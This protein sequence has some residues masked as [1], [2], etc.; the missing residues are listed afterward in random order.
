MIVILAAALAGCGGSGG[1][2]QTLLSPL[3]PA[4]IDAQE[5]RQQGTWTILV[6]L[7]ADNDLET[8]GLL[9]FNQME[10][11]GSTK[12]VRIVVQ[13]DR[14]AGHDSTN[15]NWTDT[16]RY[17]VTR[18]SD[19]KK[20]NSIRLDTPALGELNMSD[21]RTLKDFVDWG[22]REFPADH[23]C[24]I[25]WDH[26]SGWQIR[27][28]SLMPEY[29]YVISDDTSGDEMNV[30]EIP[31]ALADVDIDV[32]AFDAC[33][34]QQLEIAYEL[35]N[36]ASY[37]VGSA[38]TEPSPGYN[39]SSLFSRVNADTTPYKL[40]ETIVTQ[41]ARTYPAPRTAITQSAVDLSQISDVK[42][43][44]DQLAQALISNSTAHA[45]ELAAARNSALNYS[46]ASDSSDRYNLDLLDYASKC[47]AALGSDVDSAYTNLVSAMQSAVIAET[48]NPD[49]P[50]ASGLAVYVPSPAAYDSRYNLL[51]LA[52]DSEW[53]N[54]L[55][56]Q[57]K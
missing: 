40:C 47:S 23:Y 35:K 16:R 37:L 22:T 21:W 53:D 30:T 5:A 4:I 51:D 36:S 7:D 28:L 9:N 56:A 41:Y 25:L 39:Y 18:D 44:V 32:I 10:T 11:V 48:H 24:L 8:A 14:I 27:T 3:S 2:N 42:S 13:M 50:E 1:G 31:Q 54:W 45:N 52:A 6:Y 43:S 19:P 49:M 46:V 20:I 34:M 12:D 29:K 17:L 57:V 15:D 55:R 26:G 38:A 33:F